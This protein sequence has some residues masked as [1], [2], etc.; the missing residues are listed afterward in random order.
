M[1]GDAEMDMSVGD[2]GTVWQRVR[3]VDG[4]TATSNHFVRAWGAV[5]TDVLGGLLYAAAP[6]PMSTQ[7][8]SRSRA[9]CATGPGERTRV[10]AKAKMSNFAVKRAHHRTWPQP[11]F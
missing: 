7:T 10:S 11:K 8:D 3:S 6:Q 9:A 1:E 2:S 5:W 4:F